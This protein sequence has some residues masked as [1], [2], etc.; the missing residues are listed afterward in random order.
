MNEA[1]ILAAIYQ[2]YGDGRK[3]GCVPCE[4]CGFAPGYYFVEGAVWY[5]PMCYCKLK[6]M[7]G[8]PSSEAE[9][10]EFIH[11]STSEARAWVTLRKKEIAERA[12]LEREWEKNPPVIQKPKRRAKRERPA[13]PPVVR[14]HKR[15][16]DRGQMSFFNNESAGY[17]GVP[18][19]EPR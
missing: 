15:G 19:A 17:C 2:L 10:R 13:P 11:S 14:S 7:A 5:D 8:R 6:P 9:L 4:D 18:E 12:E 1:E 16:A 3:M